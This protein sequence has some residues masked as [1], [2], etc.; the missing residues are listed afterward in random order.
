[1]KKRMLLICLLAALLL[2]G[3]AMRTVE[4]MYS[5]P[6]R[7]EG[8]TH[9]QKIIDREMAGMEY[10]APVSGDNQQTVQLADL[11]GDGQ[12]EFLVFAKGSSENPLQILI[13]RREDEG[14][15]SLL[16][17]IDCSGEQFEQ[18][19]YRD[20]DGQPGDE[21][22]L[23]R[24]LSDNTLRIASVYSFASGQADQILSTVYARLLTTDLDGDGCRELLVIR[25]GQTD[26]DKAAAILFTARDGAVER[27]KEVTL[28]EAAGNIRRVITAPL[29]GDTPGV[30]IAS[31]VNDRAIVT[32]IL[33]RGPEGTLRNLTTEG[34]ETRVETLRNYYI[35]AEDID[36]DGVPELPSL[37]A[38]KS[39]A[40]DS[41]VRQQ[42][43]RWYSVDK[44]GN[45]TDKA[46]T[47]HNFGGGWYL[48]LDST[49]IRR[50]AAEQDGSTYRFYMWNENF[51]EATAL[52]S[53]YT[54]TGKDRD[55]QADAGNRFA[56]YRGESVVYAAKLEVASGMYGVTE[57]YL[58]ESFRLIRQGRAE[59]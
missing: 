35:D 38:M 17:R 34:Q 13:L 41:G 26:T 19:E 3:C 37:L 49:L 44:D 5:P 42:L 16:D 58:I 28:S 48:E 6:R 59:N 27:S 2:E 36:G 30:Y 40:T 39:I 46:F 29:E 24:R 57:D 23:G 45:R 31:T 18:V 55:E 4:Q 11:D 7:S 15:F 54:F 51:T 33:T 9:L 20:M 53:L 25:S 21:I 47:F 43:I 1:M 52:F 50:I 10:A 12:E 22:I 32:D 14:N 8:F 56:L